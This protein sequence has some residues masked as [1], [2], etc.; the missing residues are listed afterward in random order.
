MDEYITT[1][2]SKNLEL[3]KR[4]FELEEQLRVYGVLKF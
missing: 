1:V 4:K 3:D 2:G